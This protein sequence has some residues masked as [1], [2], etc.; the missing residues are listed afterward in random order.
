[1]IA[2]YG[3]AFITQ[4]PADEEDALVTVRSSDE[5]YPLIEQGPVLPAKASG[6]A[7]PPANPEEV[8]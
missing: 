1:M 4:I 3:S 5:G 6:E 8:Q 7:E 2:G